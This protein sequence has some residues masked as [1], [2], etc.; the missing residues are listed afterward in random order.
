MCGA[1]SSDRKKMQID[2][3]HQAHDST[4]EIARFLFFA[5]TVTPSLSMLLTPKWYY[6]GRVTK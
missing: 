2:N 5:S 3:A 1:V 6:N 4:R